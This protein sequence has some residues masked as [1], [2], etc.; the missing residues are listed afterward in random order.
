M[1]NIKIGIKGVSTRDGQYVVNKQY[2]GHSIY[3]R[4]GTT[5][6]ITIDEVQKFI[7]KQMY[8]IDHPDPVDAFP[9]ARSLKI[10]KALEYLWENHLKH[11]N[12]AKEIKHQLTRLDER[13]GDKLVLSIRKTDIQMYKRERLKDTN[14]NKGQKHKTISKR[15]LQSEL[16]YLAQAFN[17]LVD[18]GHIERNHIKGFTYVKL[19]TCH[20]VILDDGYENGGE[21]R[22]I[23]SNCTPKV[24]PLIE[25]LYE[26][27][28]RP[29]E[30]FHLRWHWIQRKT[31]NC[32]M[33][34]IPAEEKL[35]SKQIFDEKTGN[36]HKVPLSL[37][38]IEV[39]KE[40]GIRE[41][42]TAL[43]FPSPVTLQPRK[44]IR[45]AFKTALK[46]SDLENTDITPY[47]LR[48]TRLTIWDEIDSNGA[49]YAGGHVARDVHERNYVKVS[50]KRLFKLVGIDYDAEM[51]VKTNNCPTVIHH[52]NRRQA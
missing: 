3:K 32:W 8:L 19:D 17:L 39:L 11:K 25:F 10:R 18:D 16:N 23:L 38:A 4:L 14:R 42:C 27:G 35:D 2:K 33:L 15:T 20:P 40:V 48:R 13:L 6:T 22:A 28:L 52:F 30:L 29:K 9:D 50:S 34:V 31:D 51:T 36:S 7:T 5:E 45:T 12:Y 43:I 26:T 49:R 24:R 44:D 21:Y 41:D 1:G 46:K 37:R 47:A